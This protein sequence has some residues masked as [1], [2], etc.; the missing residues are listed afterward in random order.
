MKG[1]ERRLVVEQQ[2]GLGDLELEAA[3]RKLRRAERPDDGLDE[4][5]VAELGR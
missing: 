5:A 3:R 2:N 1:G 4:V